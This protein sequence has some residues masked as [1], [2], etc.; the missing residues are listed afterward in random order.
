[1]RL[2]RVP[3]GVIGADRAHQQPVRRCA[4]PE[5]ER[6]EDLVPDE[7][8]DDVTRVQAEHLPPGRTRLRAIEESIVAVLAARIDQGR[9]DGDVGPGIDARATAEFLFSTSA[10]LRILTKTNDVR[11]LHRIIDVALTTL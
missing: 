8:S 11:T 7:Q 5:G 10:G 2:G 9:R 3:L 1:M 4:L 6:V